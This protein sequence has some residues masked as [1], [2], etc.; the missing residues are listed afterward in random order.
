MINFKPPYYSVLDSELTYR[1]IILILTVSI[2]TFNHNYNIS[3]F[4]I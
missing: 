2:S 4:Q 3:V 1:G